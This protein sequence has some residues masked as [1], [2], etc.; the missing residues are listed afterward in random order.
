[1]QQL[2]KKVDSL[3]EFFSGLTKE[4]MW[5]ESRDIWSLHVDTF[6]AD[7]C[8]ESASS[9]SHSHGGRRRAP[10]QRFESIASESGGVW[11]TDQ[12]GP[13]SPFIDP[14][15]MCGWIY[16]PP[17][18]SKTT[19]VIGESQAL[20]VL[21]S[22]KSIVN[23][24]MTHYQYLFLMRMVETFGELSLYLNLDTER[25]IGEV[26]AKDKGLLLLLQ[27]PRIEVNFLFPALPLASQMPRDNSMA[28]DNG[29][30]SS[31]SPSSEFPTCTP[32]AIAMMQSTVSEPSLAYNAVT[33]SNNQ[34]QSQQQGSQIML[35]GSSLDNKTRSVH[36]LLDQAGSAS[37]MLS[38]VKMSSS[39]SVSASPLNK[40]IPSLDMLTD[41]LKQGVKQGLS[42]VFAFSKTGGLS[43]PDS[44]V[45]STFSTSGS[46]DNIQFEHLE[47]EP[48]DHERKGGITPGGGEEDGLDD[49]V[50]IA[51]EV[52][53]DGL[54][55]NVG[56]EQTNCETSV[57]VTAPNF[58]PN[59][60]RSHEYET[61]SPHAIQLSLN[62]WHD[63]Y[64]LE[65]HIG[66]C[67]Y[68]CFATLI[69]K[70]DDGSIERRGCS[71]GSERSGF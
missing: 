29:T 41:N 3:S 42:T 4:M 13:P 9:S 11:G 37:A 25:V 50:E 43:T 23:V 20:S 10:M 63:F 8:F 40:P 22:S 39:L 53:E 38:A 12:L 26:A 46:S 54:G 33:I 45:A 49:N 65:F 28:S 5:T 56:G 55:G 64:F 16:T 57:L 69:D 32:M 47:L 62:K 21:V 19:P 36:T 17:P 35:S 27:I 70:C 15:P 34:Q 7:F 48:G 61:V 71:P 1:M 68:I 44:E 66:S 6:W 30:Q 52:C 2:Q 51:M 14:V 60:P 58:V 31:P 67:L 59:G 24:Q 18:P